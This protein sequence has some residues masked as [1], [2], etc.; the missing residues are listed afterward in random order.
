[1]LRAADES[2]ALESTGDLYGYY[3]R[4]TAYFHMN[5]LAEAKH[6]ALQA[7]E[8]DVNRDEPSL[9]LLLAKIYQREGDVANAIEQL[10]QLLKR[11]ADRQRED[12]AKQLLAELESQPAT[13]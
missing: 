9:S 2:V 7:V 4:A 10:H 8:L 6:S 12:A 13:K 3:Y 1:V 5:K 11:P